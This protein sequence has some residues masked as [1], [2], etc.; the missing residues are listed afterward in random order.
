MANEILKGLGFHHMALYATDYEKSKTFYQALG[1]KPI[2]EWGEG[3]GR[4][5][6]LD[7]GNGDRIELFARGS[8]AYPADGKWNHFALEAEDVDEAYRIA[9]EAG[10]TPHIPPKTVPL[11][12]R[13]VKITIRCGFVKGPDGEQIE[14]F[15]QLA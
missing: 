12:S 4:I 3:T 10:A 15:K 2:V 6:L 5:M 1:M 9:L 7:V 13:P 8:D 14:F 11:D